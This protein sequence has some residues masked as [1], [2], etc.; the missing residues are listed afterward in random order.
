MKK[1]VFLIVILLAGNGLMFSQISVS[2]DGSAPD[3][4]AM[5]D[6]KSTDRGV[7]IPRMTASQ[8]AGISSPASGLLVYQTDAPAGFYYY[9]G[10][11][12]IFLGTG[13]GGSGHMIDMD[14]NAY[15]TVKIG[16]QEWMAENLRVTHYRNG[17]TI[18]KVNGGEAWCVLTTGVYC[19]YSYD[20]ATYKIPYGAL[21]NWY[22]VDD[23]RNLCP[24]GWH[25]PTDEEW[26]TLTTYLGGESVAGGKIKAAIRWT[27]PNAGA[28]NTNGFSGFPGGNL[29]CMFGG[30][31]YIGLF[32]YWWTATQGEGSFAWLRCVGYDNSNIYRYGYW[33]NSGF[34]VRC[35]RDD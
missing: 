5:L 3:N 30:C 28:T 21:Y 10:T 6:V 33:K 29:D 27:P 14:G 32:G 18:A 17:D 15:P 22:A 1:I 16:D 26:T 13:E 2:T 25:M 35:V 20:E 8:R 4:S 9:N 7:L 34:S 12:W 24:T 23:S 31:L 19:W 11:G